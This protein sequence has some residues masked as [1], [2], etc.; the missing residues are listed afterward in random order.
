MQGQQHFNNQYGMPQ[1]RPPPGSM[2]LPQGPP[3]GPGGM[4]SKPTMPTIYNHQRRAS[5]YPSPQQILQKRQ[6]QYPNGTQVNA[7]FLIRVSF[8]L[9]FY[10]INEN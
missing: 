7:Q 2:A 3:P 9:L 10:K 1:Q 6:Q 4:P 5:P 8:F